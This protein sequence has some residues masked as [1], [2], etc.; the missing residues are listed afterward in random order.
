MIESSIEMRMRK[1][2]ER[3]PPGKMANLA[4]V[5]TKEDGD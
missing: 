4:G 1:G 5:W 2:D 3:R